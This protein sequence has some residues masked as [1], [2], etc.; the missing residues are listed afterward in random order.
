MDK[1]NIIVHKSYQFGL[2]IVK[3]YIFLR[4]IRWRG[5]C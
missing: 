4:K 1:E 3:L 5:N 2:R